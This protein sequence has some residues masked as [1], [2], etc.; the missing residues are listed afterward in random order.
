M[1]LNNLAP[2]TAYD[3][4]VQGAKDGKTTDWSS[5]Y[6]FTTVPLSQEEI[7]GISSISI[8]PANQND[9][10]YDLNGRRINEQP[11]KS[12]LYIH[13]GKKILRR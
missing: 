2:G 7:D 6:T 12:G 5:V 8:S 11:R 3:V 1:V 10:W 13:N 9:V 4:Q